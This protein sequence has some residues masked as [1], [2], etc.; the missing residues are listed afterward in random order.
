MKVLRVVLV[1]LM[2]MGLLA[3]S[4]EEGLSANGGTGKPTSN[5]V[6]A[7]LCDIVFNSS[8]VARDKTGTLEVL[9]NL[10][11]YLSVYHN[12][13][14]NLYSAV[15][16]GTPGNT[17]GSGYYRMHYS[18][19]LEFQKALKN[20]FSMEMLVKPD[21]MSSTIGLFASLQDGGFGLKLVSSKPTFTVCCDQ[22]VSI[23]GPVLESGKYYHIV[24]VWDFVESKAILYVD[25]AQAASKA[26]SGKLTFPL[27]EEARWIALGANCN[28]NINYARQSFN[29][30]I[31][32]A[33]IYDN[34]LS[35]ANVTSMYAKLRRPQTAS[36]MSLSEVAFLNPCKI[37]H[38][39]TY[40]IYGKGFAQGDKVV[41]ESVTDKSNQVVCDA[42]VQS[43]KV[44]VV[45][46]SQLQT[47]TY[48]I[49]V[50][51]GDNRKLL[52]NV[53]FT[54]SDNP[55]VNVKTGVLAHRCWHTNSS[56]GPYENSFAAF[57]KTL[58]SGLYGAE[59]DCWSTL[60][61]VVVVWHD[62]TFNGIQIQNAK[63][64]R[65]KDQKMPDGS[66]LATLE[67]FIV[68]GLKYPDSHLAFEIKKHA[69]KEAN[70]R[71]VMAVAE[72]LKKYKP[73]R[74]QI[75]VTSF[76]LDI[77]KSLR[78][79]MKMEELNLALHGDISPDELLTNGIDGMA[80]NMN[81]LS[82]HPE[83][84]Q[85]AKAK[86]MSVTCWLP[87]RIEDMATFIGLGVDA[88][89]VNDV[90]LAKKMTERVYLSKE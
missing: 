65:F 79:L 50:K 39:Y 48:L 2:T 7:D 17:V 72:L 61:G 60:D 69:T 35:D 36:S 3:C 88:M 81:V 5:T 71:C 64:E 18:E 84:I 14:Y 86:N 47:D 41:F 73:S 37:A 15:Y 62:A 30:E 52:G 45:L 90:A 19:N 66:S 9:S 24:A 59:F 21:V 70:D 11:S 29:G 27:D 22:E 83:W 10:G 58:K 8:R 74:S 38:G 46:P 51:R 33:R 89:T 54:L 80:Y 28:D 12:Q 75:T 25:G 4:K 49:Y 13:D 26:T 57:Q 67:S 6:K 43:E 31:A 63:Y 16:T 44:T 40:H 87:S 42:T 53:S 20:G 85:Q 78:G 55:D 82:A 34:V 23:S 76:Y 56:T 68:E 77:L 1:V 32:L